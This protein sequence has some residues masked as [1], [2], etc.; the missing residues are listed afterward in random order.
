LN[1]GRAVS[2][3]DFL[4]QEPGRPVYDPL[5]LLRYS[6]IAREPIRSQEGPGVR[7][8]FP[9]PRVKQT[10]RSLNSGGNVEGCCINRRGVA[11]GSR[12]RQEALG[13]S[14]RGGD[15]LSVRSRNQVGS[16]SSRHARCT[17]PLVARRLLRPASVHAAGDQSVKKAVDELDAARSGG[18]FRASSAKSGRPRS[19]RSPLLSN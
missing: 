16:G 10:R 6:H 9:Q 11:A 17:V 3:H 7:I 4:N 1:T 5:R 12:N 19:R 15:S 8:L 13:S 14:R 2:L 18:A